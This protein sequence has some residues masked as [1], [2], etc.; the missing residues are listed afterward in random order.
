MGPTVT[1]G[2]DSPD[3]LWPTAGQRQDSAS[4]S[5]ADQFADLAFNRVQMPGCHGSDG[6]A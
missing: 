2:D 4:P 3:V 1:R 6:R 5:L